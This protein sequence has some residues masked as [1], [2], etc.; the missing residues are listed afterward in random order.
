MSELG[1][2]WHPA[3]VDDTEEL[4]FIAEQS[5]GMLETLDWYVYWIGGLGYDSL[6]AHGY[7]EGKA[8]KKLRL[9]ETYE[10]LTL[11]YDKPICNLLIHF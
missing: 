11:A 4:E 7:S 6:E 5:R 8:L 3:F 1:F 9:G 2:G 10:G